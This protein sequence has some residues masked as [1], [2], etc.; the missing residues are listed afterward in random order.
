MEFI[1]NIGSSNDD[2]VFNGGDIGI[3]IAH[4]VGG[5]PEEC[6][7][8]AE[9]LAERGHSVSCP[10]LLG[11]GGSQI[12][13]GATSRWHWQATLARAHEDLAKNCRHI[14]V[15][16]YLTGALL[17]LSLSKSLKVQPNAVVLASPAVWPPGWEARPL[18]QALLA[19]NIKRVA[20]W[21]KIAERTPYGISDENCRSEALSAVD[22]DSAWH[23]GVFWRTAG[24]ALEAGRLANYV[25]PGLCEIT[26]PALLLLPR[27]G[28]AEAGQ[29]AEQLQLGLGG[30]VEVLTLDDSLYR[31][32]EDQ[33]RGLAAERIGEFVER[34]VR[35]LD[36]AQ[37]DE[38]GGTLDF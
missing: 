23:S 24:V 25:M 6:A 37:A 18:Q 35:E 29:L 11:H 3:L 1:E 27:I 33:Q 32:L 17:A 38:D 15:A 21:L 16:G 14:V 36:S 9:K 19:L 10:M 20:N 4:S 13:L 26:T 22:Q 5:T 30:R 12:L 2:I 31:V 7:Y 28:D 34:I 8:L